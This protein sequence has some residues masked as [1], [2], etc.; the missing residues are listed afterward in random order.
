M[1][2]QEL[3]IVKSE[4]LPE[5]TLKDQQ[6]DSGSMIPLGAKVA[7][8]V[9]AITDAVRAAVTNP[10]FAK[11][12]GALANAGT[13]LAGVGHGAWTGNIAEV[14]AAPIAGWRA[15]KGGYWLGKGMQNAVTGPVAR[16]AYALEPFAQAISK[17]S[18]AQG[19]LD[20]AQM[21]DQTRQDIGS[22]GVA[23]ETPRTDEEKAAHP[24]LVNALVGKVG[25]LA[26]TLKERG[27]PAAEAMAVKLISDGNAATF[28]K[29]M[30]LYMRSRSVKP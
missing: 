5:L 14:I 6:S 23:L 1:A 7:S 11:R 12:V 17:A 19:V 15:G 28:G 25:E 22:L 13:T 8:D 29:L 20:L 30:T 26:S 18:G 3:T 4:P 27:I 24:A 9:P 21:A 16:A 2:D 10:N